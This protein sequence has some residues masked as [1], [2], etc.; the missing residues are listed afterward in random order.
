MP[1]K[2]FTLLC[3]PF[4]LGACAVA[5][6]EPTS[7]PVPS[8][9][10]SP[11]PTAEWERSGWE[12]VWH[13]EFEGSELD[14]TNWTFDI[15]GNGWG[16][17]EL[18]AYTDRPENVRVENGMLVIEARHEEE[19][20]RGREYSSARLKTQGLHAWQ[21][22]R[23]EARLKLPYGQGIWPAFWMLG[24]NLYQKGWPASGEIDIMEFIGREPDHIYATVH[25]P[26]YSGGDGV[27]S[28]I[29]VSADSLRD[30]FHVYAIEWEEDEIRWFFDDEQYFKLTPADVPG[31]WIFDHPFFVILNLA[32][33]GRWPGYPDDNTVFPQFLYVDYVRVYQ[34]S[35]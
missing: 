13:D 14:T 17:Q 29:T 7:T 31:E 5:T 12:I 1:K 20:I 15:G 23:I 30:D 16:N 22:G 19:L 9:T 24:D 35:P 4:L 34:Q 28:N 32:V 8:A 25:A 18:Q 3:I 6:P 33:G 11:S 10:P 27:G 26:G 2:P 21:Y